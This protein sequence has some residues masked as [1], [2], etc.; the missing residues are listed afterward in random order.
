MNSLLNST[1]VQRHCSLLI[2]AAP[3]LLLIALRWSRS[4]FDEA[5]LE[6]LQQS[7]AEEMTLRKKDL[8]AN[9]IVFAI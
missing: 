7:L 5:L 2:A 4:S 9:Y 3:Y 6:K 1:G 8:K